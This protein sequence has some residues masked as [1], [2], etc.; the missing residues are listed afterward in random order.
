MKNYPIFISGIPRS[1]STWVANVISNSPNT[2]YIHEPDNERHTFAGL[3]YKDK[4]P[5]FPRNQLTYEYVTLFERAFYGKFFTY[6]SIANK[7]LFL[8]SGF[9]RKKIEDQLADSG[10]NDIKVFRD[11]F[12]VNNLIPGGTP[13]ERR[14]VKSVHSLLVLKQLL[15]IFE[16]PT[17]IT[18][19]NP[20]GIVSSCL[21]MNNPDIDRKLYTDANLMDF[22]YGEKL[23][24]WKRLATIEARAGFQVGLFYR[25]IDIMLPLL[26]NCT[27]IKHEDI[28]QN[29]IDKFRDLFRIL[30][31]KFDANSKRFIEK[32]NKPGDG[33]ETNRISSEMINGWKKKISSLQIA[34]IR[35]GFRLSRTTFYQDF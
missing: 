34:E 10:K 33:Y 11:I 29:P 35:K 30:D 9:D 16:V 8:L 32:T 20:G 13:R 5:R 28:C 26:N 24:D 25:Y 17:V 27:V 19:R 21:S 7:I 18:V 1:G 22:L 3:Y 31:M 14:V 12:W 2:A 23:P 6:K 15:D 4:L